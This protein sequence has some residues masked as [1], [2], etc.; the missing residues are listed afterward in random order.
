MSTVYKIHRGIYVIRQFF[1]SDLCCC[2]ILIIPETVHY[3]AFSLCSQDLLKTLQFVLTSALFWWQSY[4][5]VHLY[6]QHIEHNKNMVTVPE[7]LLH[8]IR[9][10]VYTT[11]AMGMHPARILRQRS[12][13]PP[14]VLFR[15]KVV[16]EI[17]EDEA[18]SGWK[19]GPWYEA[20]GSFWW[21][22]W[23]GGGMRWE[24]EARPGQEVPHTY[25]MLTVVVYVMLSLLLVILGLLMCYLTLVSG[26]PSHLPSMQPLLSLH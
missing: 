20:K 19:I 10:C 25:D 4:C 17:N 12:I 16:Q 6:Y 18:S 3:S 1:Q 5:N 23:K 2:A 8:V 26:T 13:P 7:Q 11:L 24:L 14:T 9:Q 15:R 22:E 21:R